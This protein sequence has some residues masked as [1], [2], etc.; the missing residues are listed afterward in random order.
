MSAMLGSGPTDAERMPSRPHKVLHD[1]GREPLQNHGHAKT[2]SPALPQAIDHST[3]LL[4]IST[5]PPARVPQSSPRQGQASLPKRWFCTP[6]LQL[7]K[8]L[9]LTISLF[10]PHKCYT[11]H[12]SLLR[13]IPPTSRGW[14]QNLYLIISSTAPRA[15]CVSCL[16]NH[17]EKRGG[18]VARGFPSQ[19][20]SEERKDVP[21]CGKIDW[22]RSRWTLLSTIQPSARPST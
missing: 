10:I 6:T 11:L 12:F 15:F 21:L 8:I 14:S 7:N 5:A 13:R 22:Q 1:P 16:G 3:G 9:V 20:V 17:R 18:P 4:D 19:H 2:L